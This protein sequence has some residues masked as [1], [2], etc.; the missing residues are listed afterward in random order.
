MGELWVAA[1]VTVVGGAVAGYGAQKK[2]EAERKANRE[3][4]SAMTKEES[5][6]ASQRIGFDAALE[7]YYSQKQR[8]ETQRGLDQFR[9]FST[10]GQ[11]APGIDDQGGRIVLPEAPQ[12]GDFAV[13]EEIVQNK[14]NPKDKKKDSTLTKA[15][16]LHDPL[17]A[18][19]GIFG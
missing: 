7:D 1:A 10:M 2:A 16:K 5:E 4:A 14:N 15:M 8:F 18:A 6:L 13:Q 3:D 19:L 12:Y 9:Q 11:F 17:G